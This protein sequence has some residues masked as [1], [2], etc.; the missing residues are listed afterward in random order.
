MMGS[1]WDLY[2]DH[3]VQVEEDMQLGSWKLAMEA[4]CLN[5]E[6]HAPLGALS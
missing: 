4:L 3:L 1:R 6:S 2:D 5:M